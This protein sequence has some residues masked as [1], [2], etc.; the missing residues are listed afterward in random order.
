MFTHTFSLMIR[1]DYYTTKKK[2]LLLDKPHNSEIHLTGKASFDKVDVSCL[3][4]Q[5]VYCYLP[6]D[7]TCTVLFRDMISISYKNLFSIGRV[8]LKNPQFVFLGGDSSEVP[9]FLDPEC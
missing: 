5:Y 3:H 8:I 4:P 9:Q 6:E 2:I 7:T 1:L